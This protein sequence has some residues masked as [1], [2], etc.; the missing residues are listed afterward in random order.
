MNLWRGVFA[1]AAF[2]N[3]LVGGVM[4]A[5]PGRA[6]AAIGAGADPASVQFAGWL[7]FTFGIGYAMVA[8]TPAS[9]RGI[10]WIGAIGK[11]GA[12]AIALWRLFSRGGYVP[13]QAVALPLVDLLFVA[14]FALFLWRGPR[15][16]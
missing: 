4:T 16:G 7:I 5:A 10:V 14:V 2:V 6:A 13:A 3:F 12:V 11:F 15:P 8:R 1:L 9:H